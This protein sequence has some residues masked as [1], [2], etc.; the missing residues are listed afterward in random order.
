[1]EIC[2]ELGTVEKRNGFRP[3]PAPMEP[4]GCPPYCLAGQFF[5]EHTHRQCS[6]CG[7]VWLDRVGPTDPKSERIRA[8]QRR[9]WAQEATALAAASLTPSGK[10]RK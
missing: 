5:G 7:R 4:C 9:R 1:M 10:A 8:G 6:G 2:C 3:I